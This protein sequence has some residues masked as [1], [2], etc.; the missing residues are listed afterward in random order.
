MYILTTTLL[1][2]Y[3]IC[4]VTRML[5]VFHLFKQFPHLVQLG[6][7][8]IFS[9]PALQNVAML[10]FLLF[11]I[12][13]IACM[14]LFGHTQYTNF[15]TRHAN[16]TSFTSSMVTLCR[17]VTGESWNGIMRDCMIQPPFCSVLDNTCGNPTAAVLIFVSF[18]IF[19][20]MLIVELVLAVILNQFSNELEKED[21]LGKAFATETDII[22]FATLWSKYT[23]LH[24][25]SVL[26]LM[27]LLHDNDL[28][29]SF[30][31]KK[32]FT[33]M[34]NRDMCD[35]ID[36]LHI[37]CDD[38]NNVHYL[39]VIHQLGE[40]SFY[41]AYPEAIDMYNQSKLHI[42]SNSNNHSNNLTRTNTGLTNVSD[43]NDV[44][45]TN[46]NNE[47]S[48]NHSATTTTSV[49]GLH[50]VRTNSSHTA[51]GL[52]RL[53]SLSQTENATT[54]AGIRLMN[55]ELILIRQQAHRVFPQFKNQ[56]KFISFAGQT[57]RV[58]IMQKVIRG[59]LI[60]KRYNQLRKT[61]YHSND[62]N[63]NNNNNLSDT[64][65]QPRSSPKQHRTHNNNIS[66]YDIPINQPKE[67]MLYTITNAAYTHHKQASKHLINSPS[68]VV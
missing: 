60:R 44:H 57:N 47:H 61:F 19:S 59:F 41:I 25:M 5:R 20:S 15:M 4:F 29:R 45:N 48:I 49:A 9:L 12:Y 63:D 37:P 34:N 42:S 36:T 67:P 13:S 30:D 64:Q 23:H 26:R 21:R 27:S 28:P 24:T 38:E 39:D 52:K 10:L 7:T 2:Y 31:P 17:M 18:E 35:F 50:S 65:P 53:H 22:N 40:R 51:R 16:F 3:Y 1:L 66:I 8:I 58:M 62:D 55:D 46:N 32:Q 68:N 56:N 14:N 11:F 33:T 54:T 6:Q 43:T